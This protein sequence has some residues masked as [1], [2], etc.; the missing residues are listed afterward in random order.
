[1]KW[2][3]K[4]KHWST[5]KLFTYPK[6]LK[7][8]FMWRTNL[9]SGE[10]KGFDHEFIEYKGLPEEQDYTSF[11]SYINNSKNKYVVS[12]NNLSGN[13]LLVIPMPRKNKNFATIKDFT[14]NASAAHQKK[15]WKKVSVLTRKEFKKHGSVYVST[16]GLGVSYLHVRISHKP[17]HYY[18]SRFVK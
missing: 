7:G 13:T 6:K 2:G 17:I 11:K 14:D 16:H 9:L 3:T 18:N 4:L 10:K 12:F 8:K 1:M 5:G 15:F